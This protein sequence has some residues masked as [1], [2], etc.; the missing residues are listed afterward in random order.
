VT[1]PGGLSISESLASGLLPIFI[2]PI[3]GQETENIKALAE[4]GI[5]VY[6]KNI[7][8]IRDIVLDLKNNPANLLKSKDMIASFKKPDCLKNI[9]DVIR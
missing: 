1:K 3:P 5:G 2:S 9:C 6:A 8:S 4:Y 7:A